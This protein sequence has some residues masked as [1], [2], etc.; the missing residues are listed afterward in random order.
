M[1][2]AAARMEQRSKMPLMRYFLF[3]GAALLAL[4]FATDMYAPKPGV[5]AATETAIDYSPVVRIRS[6]R[7]W[8]ERIVFDT[9][10]AATVPAVI[11]APITQAQADVP[12]PTNIAGVSSAARVRGAF[13]LLDPAYPKT[14]EPKLQPK[15]KIAKSRVAPPTILAA[16]HQQVLGFF[17]N[18]TW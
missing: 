1:V 18:S 11:P 10:T 3:V 17:A 8:P 9:S 14:P 13:A 15:R 7:K 16:Q 6:D 2:H 12:A 4:L 5:T